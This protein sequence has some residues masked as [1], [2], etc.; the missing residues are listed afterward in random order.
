MQP[1]PES[2]TPRVFV[3]YWA[4]TTHAGIISQNKLVVLEL[5]KDGQ[6]VEWKQT[7][8][9]E[10]GYRFWSIALAGADGLTAVNFV[11]PPDD[12][13]VPA[14]TA[15]QEVIDALHAAGLTEDDAAGVIEEGNQYV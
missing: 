4:S 11:R 12:T 10:D 13:P 7:P 15:P 8:L 9:P 6:A 2:L 1:H 3:S 14:P 5:L